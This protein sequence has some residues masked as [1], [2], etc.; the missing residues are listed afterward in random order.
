MIRT[1]KVF[2]TDDVE[3]LQ[4]YPEI[5]FYIVGSGSRASWLEQ[6]ISRRGL[7]NVK[8]TGRLPLSDMPALFS[9]ASALMVTLNDDPI[10]AYTIPS[11]LQAYL[12]VGRPVIACLN[13]EGARVIEAS[14]AGVTCP[15]EDASAL[16][17]SVLKLYAMP[18]KERDRLGE[19]GRRY[20]SEHFESEKLVC[21]LIEHF[22]AALLKHGRKKA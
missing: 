7:N 15:A 14:G 8:L 10:L 5:R 13:G 16:A 3:K 17:D 11:K 1:K 12:A 21:A 9:A 18:P 2:L 20:F 6:E 19:L 4:L 22:E